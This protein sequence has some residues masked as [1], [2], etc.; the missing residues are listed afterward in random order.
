MIEYEGDNTRCRQSFDLL[1][2]ETSTINPAAARNTSNY[3]I[4]RTLTTQVSG[5]STVITENFGLNTE[6]SGFYLALR[7]PGTCIIIYRLVVFYYACPS[8]IVNLVARPETIAPVFGSS[9]Q[10]SVTATCVS[11]SSPIGGDLLLV[12]LERGNWIASPSGCQCNLGF[13]LNLNQ[14]CLRKYTNVSYTMLMYL[15]PPLACGPGFYGSVANGQCLICPSNSDST[16]SGPV[17]ACPCN[18]GYYR[19]PQEVD[20]PCTR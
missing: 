7:D 11:D 5:S 12:C 1:K 18:Q 9:E 6:E 16:D 14:E 20:L 4:I 17:D 10:L 8:E 3:D 13:F 2:Y 15:L 19:T